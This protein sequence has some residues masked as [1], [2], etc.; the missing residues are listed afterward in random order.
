MPSRQILPTSATEIGIGQ[1]E[2]SLRAARFES[3]CVP[4]GHLP[5]QGQRV[6]TNQGQEVFSRSRMPVDRPKI[7][8]SQT[9]RRR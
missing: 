1:G 2:I 8:G 7:S 4:I 3:K 6:Q 5:Q 9:T